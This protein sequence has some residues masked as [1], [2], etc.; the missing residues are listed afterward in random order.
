MKKTFLKHLFT[1]TPNIIFWLIIMTFVGFGVKHSMD[2]DP[3]NTADW[4]FAIA[5]FMTVVNV[6]ATYVD[7]RKRFKK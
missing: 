1:G 7:W 5:G 6:V 4:L 2:Y 3:Y